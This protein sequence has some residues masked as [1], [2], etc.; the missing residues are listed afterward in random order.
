MMF[1][2]TFAFPIEIK[3]G[4]GFTVACGEGDLTIATVVAGGCLVAVS[5]SAPGGVWEAW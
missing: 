1:V 2:K 4:G 5:D 3:R